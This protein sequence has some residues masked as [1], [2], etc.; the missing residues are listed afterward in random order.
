MLNLKFRLIAEDFDAAEVE[1]S[2]RNTPI[3]EICPV[4]QA[5]KRLTHMQ[6]IVGV[7]QARTP[8]NITVVLI[9]PDVQALGTYQPKDWLIAKAK[10]SDLPE[11]TAKEIL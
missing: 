3:T 2:P 10:L 1:L 4:A 5:L 8:D 6:W 7:D 9:Y 11:I